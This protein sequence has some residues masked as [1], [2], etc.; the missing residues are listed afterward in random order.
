[1]I[2]RE[3]VHVV[4]SI[5]DKVLLS[6]SNATI[7]SVREKEK[8]LFSISAIESTCYFSDIFRTSFL[9]L[10]VANSIYN[11]VSTIVIM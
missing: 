3:G 10:D 6:R 5:A 7:T 4:S 1:M 2:L 8:E 11:N 9:P